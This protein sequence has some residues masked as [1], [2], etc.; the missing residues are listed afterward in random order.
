M[1]K[2]TIK[3]LSTT[4]NPR[5]KKTK[6]HQKCAKPYPKPPAPGTPRNAAGAR[7]IFL[8][9]SVSSSNRD[10][11]PSVFRF[12]WFWWFCLVRFF[13]VS[14]GFDGFKWFFWNAVLTF[15]FI[16]AFCLIFLKNTFEMRFRRARLRLCGFEVVFLARDMAHMAGFLR[17]SRFKTSQ[18]CWLKPRQNSL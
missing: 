12:W 9:A 8:M 6:K 13:E 14:S 7:L 2:T 5:K 17:V 16:V 3:P 10:S 11:S 18:T 1:C 4:I 15:G